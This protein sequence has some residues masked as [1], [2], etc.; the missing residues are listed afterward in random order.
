MIKHNFIKWKFNPKILDSDDYKLNDKLA[1][2]SSKKSFHK[3]CKKY[4][5]ISFQ[6]I[7][8]LLKFDKNIYDSFKGSGVDLGG[9]IG[10][11][12]SVIAKKKNIKNVYCVEIV[13]NAVKFC[14]PKIKKKVLGKNF[15]KVISVNGSFDELNLKDNSVD[16]CVAWDSMHHSRNVFKTLM[17]A[18][19]V[20]KKYGKIIIIDRAHNNDTTNKEINRMLNVVYPK[21]FLKENYLPLN[22][23]L[24]R[25]MNGEHE[26]RFFEW[27]KF[28]RKSKLKI[29]KKIIF[30]ES[31]Y[32]DIKNKTKIFE[33]KVTFKVGSFNKEK[34]VYLLQK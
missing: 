30:K 13:K 16:F 14:Q 22:K 10:L 34:I 4:T 28:F 24:T 6:N 7:E 23:I 5:H 15:K 2:I 26:Y 32:E 19:R 3:I 17:E 12:S 27:E 21:I 29:L 1:L 11:V 33:K 9:G 20:L 18:R 8:K 31:K 25:K